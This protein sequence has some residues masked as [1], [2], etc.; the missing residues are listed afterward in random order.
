MNSVVF[1]IFL[2]GTNKFYNKSIFLLKKIK[3][4]SIQ[5]KVKD[6]ET[7]KHFRVIIR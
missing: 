1:G 2:I 3:V 6:P 4:N 5:F 7:I